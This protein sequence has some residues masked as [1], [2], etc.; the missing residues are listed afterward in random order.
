MI[1]S[2]SIRAAG[3]YRH[4]RPG[5]RTSDAGPGMNGKNLLTRL[6]RKHL[7][8]TPGAQLFRVPGGAREAVVAHPR[9]WSNSAGLPGY[10]EDAD[11]GMAADLL[12]H[13]YHHYLPPHWGLWAQRSL[14]A[15]SRV[16]ITRPLRA[17]LTA[18]R[19]LIRDPETKEGFPLEVTSANE[20]A[21][22][23]PSL[24]PYGDFHGRSKEPG[25][26]DTLALLDSIAAE[27]A[28]RLR[29]L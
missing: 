5:H 16:S 26:S 8:D 7:T 24:Q 11:R 22:L 13:T 2:P 9:Q 10:T 20:A 18:T 14:P 15:R 3:S 1:N 12:A 19:K 27:R 23:T 21:D 25:L 17:L 28:D 29:L 6:E 4:Q